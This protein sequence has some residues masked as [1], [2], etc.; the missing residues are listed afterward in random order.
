MV[1]GKI[2]YSRLVDEAMYIIVYKVLKLVEA[3]G[4]PDKHY[5]FITFL[6]QHQGVLLPD[7]LKKQYTR[8]MTIILQHQFSDLV[9]TDK[10]FDV[11]LSF[12]GV[13]QRITVPFDSIITFADPG[14][15]FGLQFRD[16]S[17]KHSKDIVDL[18][19]TN[20]MDINHINTSE[21]ALPKGKKKSASL[22]TLPSNVISLA[23]FKKNK[24]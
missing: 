3:Q 8:E 1:E 2:D 17:E 9:V 21:A 14:V 20:I 7:F 24:K 13:K 6:T 16:V 12:E 18:T 5:F 19:D 11:S 10:H 23:Q 22:P 4:L 15:Q